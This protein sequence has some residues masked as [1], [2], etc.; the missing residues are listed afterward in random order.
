MKTITKKRMII[1]TRTKNEVKKVKITKVPF[2][3]YYG[4]FASKKKLDMENL[5]DYI[6][7]SDL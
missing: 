5:R 1:L 7:Y 3:K 2:M 6:D 4:A